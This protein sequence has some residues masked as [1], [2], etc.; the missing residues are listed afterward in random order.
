MSGGIAYVYDPGELFD[1]RC[2]LDMVELESL[3]DQEDRDHLKILLERHAQLTGSRL[4]TS[5]LDDWEAQ[6]PQ[7]VKVMPVEY[8]KVLD[9]MKMNEDRDDETISATEEVYHG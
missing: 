3:W 5:M 8:R 7:F 4:A 9:R 6:Y 1:T 2:N